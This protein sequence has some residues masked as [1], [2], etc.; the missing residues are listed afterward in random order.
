VEM[1]RAQAETPATK[2]PETRPFHL[3]TPSGKEI[4]TAVDEAVEYF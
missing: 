3:R 2:R 1:R 4:S